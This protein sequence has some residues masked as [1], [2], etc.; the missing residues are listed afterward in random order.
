MV[1]TGVVD[2]SSYHYGGSVRTG[3]IMDGIQVNYEYSQKDTLVAYTDIS[4]TTTEDT[5]NNFLDP[6]RG[7]YH[8]R[9]SDYS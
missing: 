3:S 6:F 4:Y 5:S 7:K 2:I 1:D 9:I 8:I